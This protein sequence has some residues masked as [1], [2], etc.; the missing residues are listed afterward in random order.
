MS[1]EPLC[2]HAVNQRMHVNYDT[3]TVCCFLCFLCLSIC[4]NSLRE[5]PLQQ[6][7]A[8]R[9]GMNCNAF[10]HAVQNCRRICLC[11]LEWGPQELNSNAMF[12][13]RA[14]YNM[15]VR[16]SGQLRKIINCKKSI[17]TS[18]IGRR[19]FVCHCIVDVYPCFLYWQ[20][21]VLRCA[22]RREIMRFTK[23]S[24][25]CSC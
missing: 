19:V 20:L 18:R 15:A 13:L 10:V 7:N 3:L 22:H 2:F 9:L 24:A 1:H 11:F 5:F 14:T 23:P 6:R 12:L 16:L 21:I 17:H 8:L 25:P 4:D